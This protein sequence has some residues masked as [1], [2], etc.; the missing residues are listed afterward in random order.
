MV[1]SLYELP[2]I[3]YFHD[4]SLHLMLYIINRVRCVHTYHTTTTILQGQVKV[5]KMLLDNKA[6]IDAADALLQVNLFS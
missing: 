6:E 1:A 3:I 4:N 2:L 5:V